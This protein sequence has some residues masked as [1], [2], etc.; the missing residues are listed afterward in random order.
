MIN[1]HVV[2]TGGTGFVGRTLARK[3][4][5]AGHRVTVLSRRAGGGAPAPA[6]AEVAQWNPARPSPAL[7]AGKDAVVNLVGES[8]AIGRWTEARK[9]RILDSRVVPTRS[10]VSALAAAGGERPRVLVS[11]SAVGYYGPRGD[12]DLDEDSPAGSDFLARVCVAWE[13]EAWAAEPLGVR[14]T[15]ARL[16]MVLGRDGGLLGR[17]LPVFRLGLG[18]PL[19]NGRQWLSWVHMDDVVS[20]IVLALENE[21]VRGP[22]NITSPHPVRNRDF[23]RILGRLLNRP[24]FIPVPSLALRLGLGEMA[25]LLLTGQRA[26]PRRLEGLGFK[27]RFPTLEAAL[28][29]VLGRNSAP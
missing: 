5:A 8:I 7:F 28:S 15:L 1:L 20:A 22:L 17:M 21:T 13:T 29:E 12:E 23:A 16:G 27:H 24:A 26:L 2:I 11:A 10:L 6:G 19:G 18:G 14:V 4:A 3:L 25:D 9:Q